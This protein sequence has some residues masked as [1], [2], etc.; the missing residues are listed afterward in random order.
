MGAKTNK[1]YAKRIKISKSGKL[2]TR[3]AGQNHF[4]SK[5][6]RGAKSAKNRNSEFHMSNKER[7]QFLV[8]I[9]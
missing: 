6:R 7:S 5:E 9:K 4:N 8:N 1:S 3:K 2:L